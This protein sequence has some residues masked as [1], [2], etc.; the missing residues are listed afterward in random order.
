MWRPQL[1]RVPPGW[2]FLAPDLRGFGETS[3]ET[4]V[5]AVND[6][7][8]DPR[9]S[10]D[11]LDPRDPRLAVDAYAGDLL[12]FLDALSIDRCVFAG[13]SLGGYIAFAL[14]R[15]APARIRGLVLADT[16]AEADT[17]DGR[18]GRQAL[19]AL[20]EDKGVSAVA[21]DLL[22][23]LL[24]TTTKRERPACE[25]EARRLIESNNARAISAA[26]H[27][28]MSRPDSTPDLSRIECPTLVMV[29]DED[30]IT[31]RPAAELMHGAIDGSELAVLPRAGHLSNLELPDEFSSTLA[32][33]LSRRL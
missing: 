31:A 19:L 12:G 16:R 32:G 7:S 13:L 33:F 21:D 28:L 15:L 9:D 4:D 26:I 30:T 20:L 11:S 6:D 14:F 3:I 23:K 27:A 10:S 17:P 8:R 25:R 18:R 22:P 24:G 29:G 5:G 1:D 2:R